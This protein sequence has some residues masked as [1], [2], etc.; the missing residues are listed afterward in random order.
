MPNPGNTSGPTDAPSAS[1]ASS[2]DGGGGEHF[3]AGALRADLDAGRYPHV[4]TRFPPEPNGYLH[5]GHAKA[6]TIDFGMADAFAGRCNLRLDDTNPVK[7][8]HEYIESIQTDV[9]WLGYDWAELRYASDYFQQLYDWAKLL[10]SR[11]HAYVD[12]QTAD[13]IRSARGTLTRPGTPSAQRDRPPEESLTLFEQMK[14]GELAE[15]AHVLRAKIDMA[16]PNLVMRDPVM[17]RILHAEHPRTGDAWKIYPMYDWAHGQSDWIEGVTHSL[18]DLSF[19]IH[20]PLYEW[21]LQTLRD[22][23]ASVPGVDYVPRQIEFARG[24]IAY[25]ITS[26]RKLAQLLERDVVEGWDDPRMPTIRGM[27]R[28]GFPASALRRFWEEVGVAR[29][30]NNIQYAKLEQVVRDELNT[31]AVRRMA[32]LRPLKLVITNLPED[33]TE[34]FDAVNNPEDE[35]AG[36]R[37]VSFSRELYVEQD[38]FMIDPPRKFFRM[39]PGREV[40]LRY[41]YLATCTGHDVDDDGNITC[42]YAELD[43]ESRGGNAPDGR[44]VKGTIH[45]VDAKT[46][47]AATVHEY[48]HLFTAEDPLKVPEG[49]PDDAWL[50]NVNADSRTTLTGCQLEPALADAPTDQAVQFER[51]GYFIRDPRKQ[52]PAPGS[53]NGG[54]TFNRTLTL[55]DTWAKMQKR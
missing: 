52:T 24:N 12:D 45:W 41:A 20:R 17:Y 6:I 8:E 29:R 43:L 18:C 13:Q 26:K 39:G 35:T 49:S 34:T 36:S 37:P 1:P 33:H 50:Q 55:R 38:D 11:G 2:G 23:G 19:E 54:L 5:L 32:V 9:R 3:I 47:V 31:S 21:F 30:E 42:V 15:G 44:K 40:R 10:I 53:G 28:R 51:L 22:C 48:D 25:M 4:V 46:A 14:A 27:R 16:A 7:E